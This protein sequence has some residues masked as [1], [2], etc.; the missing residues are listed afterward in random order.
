MKTNILYLSFFCLMSIPSCGN[1]CCTEKIQFTTKDSVSAL[2]LGF[3]SGKVYE[4]KNEIDLEGKVCVLPADVTIKAKGGIIKNGILVGQ[5]TKVLYK[6]TIFDRVSIKGTWIVPV[7]KSTM[8]KDLS[9]ENSL[10]DVIALT[11]Q[12]IHN[13]VIIYK[14]LYIVKTE[15]NGDACLTLNSNTD[16]TCEGT[17]QITPNAFTDYDIIRVEGENINVKGNGVIIGDKFSHLG[18]DGEWGMG[19]RVQRS[20]NIQI[21]GITVKECWG[22]CIYVGRGSENV[23][24][25][26]CT[27][28]H[29]RRQGISVTKADGVLIKNC[30]ISNVEGTLPE[31]AIDVEPNPGESTNNIVIE[32]VKVDKCKGGI[33]VYG[34]SK[35]AKVGAVTI[36]KC[37]ISNAEKNAVCILTCDRAILNKCRIKKQKTPQVIRCEDVKVLNLMYNSF[38]YD[39][40][41]ATKKI[42]SKIVGNNN[43]EESIVILRCDS[44]DIKKNNKK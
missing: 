28:L 25:D 42:A 10:K 40:I 8:F 33:L 12:E 34:R 2:S 9:Y 15:K 38:S 43:S 3:V 31:Y 17:I 29:G 20:R 4:L 44:I 37:D 11:N 24:I 14:G 7:I 27:L 39:M 36:K 1:G 6:H 5:N 41:V 18:K 30:K 26:K 22:D 21:K 13:K 19:V 32:N 23:R 35:S 16:L